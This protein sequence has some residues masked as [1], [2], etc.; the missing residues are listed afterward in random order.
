MQEKIRTA[1]YES[2]I[3]ENQFK[4]IF[5]YNEKTALPENQL[6]KKV[7]KSVPLLIK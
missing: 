1:N 3:Q 4:K 6:K 5:L 7:L 2:P